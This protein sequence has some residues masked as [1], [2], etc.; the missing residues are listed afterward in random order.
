MPERFTFEADEREVATRA[1][2]ILLNAY[3]KEQGAVPDLFPFQ[4]PFIYDN[5]L[6]YE[7]T[8]L[9]ILMKAVNAAVF[10]LFSEQN[11]GREI[12]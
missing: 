8:T 11:P 4:K 5:A 12:L 7:D 1:T 10:L 3:I 9:N 6:E 2:Q